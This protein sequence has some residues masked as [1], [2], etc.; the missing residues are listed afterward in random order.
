MSKISEAIKAVYEAQK[1]LQFEAMAALLEALE[2]ETRDNPAPRPPAAQ[3]GLSIAL[4]DE[5][6]PVRIQHGET[7][8]DL[9]FPEAAAL[10]LGLSKIGQVAEYA[11]EIRHG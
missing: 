3:E 11:E 6:N 4:T 5:Q 9:S 10:M 1:V 2:Q 7:W 8:M